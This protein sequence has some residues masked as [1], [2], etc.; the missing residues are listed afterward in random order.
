MN[1]PDLAAVAAALAAIVFQVW[2]VIVP[3]PAGAQAGT[4]V[5][6]CVVDPGYNTITSC[7]NSL[8]ACQAEAS[9]YGGTCIAVA[10]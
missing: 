7:Y 2:S 6:W 4:Q 9:G 10:Q 1:R 3:S 5:R 8:S